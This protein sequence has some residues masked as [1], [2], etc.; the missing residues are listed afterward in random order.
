MSRWFQTSSCENTKTLQTKHH[1][2]ETD[3]IEKYYYSYRSYRI[4]FDFCVFWQQISCLESRNHL[5]ATPHQNQAVFQGS[6]HVFTA[7]FWFAQQMFAQQCFGASTGVKGN[8]STKPTLTVS[9]DCHTDW[10]K[11]PTI[12]GDFWHASQKYSII[13]LC[14]LAKSPWE[15]TRIC[16]VSF[17]A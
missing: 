11:K 6:L 12:S 1:W 5:R 9:F 15:S 10:P 2:G 3:S 7:M 14:V 13:D 16:L 8:T 4:T 17:T